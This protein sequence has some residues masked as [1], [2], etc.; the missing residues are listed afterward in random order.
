[1]IIDPMVTT[2]A[3]TKVSPAPGGGSAQGGRTPTRSER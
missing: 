2:V 1:M 3:L